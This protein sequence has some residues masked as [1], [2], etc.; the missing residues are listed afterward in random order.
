MFR[1]IKQLPKIKLRRKKTNVNISY[2]CD[3]IG[4]IFWLKYVRGGKQQRNYKGIYKGT[5][6]RKRTF[7]KTKYIFEKFK[8][9]TI[10]KKCFTC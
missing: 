5:R 4:S 6:K 10:Y 7:E 1:N 9:I 3:N 2:N 8:K